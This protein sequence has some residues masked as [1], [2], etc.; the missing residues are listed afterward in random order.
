MNVARLAADIVRN[1]SGGVPRPRWCTYLVCFHCNARCGMCDSWK[2]KRGAEMTPAE[3]RTVFDKIGALDVVRLSGGEPFLRP[4]FAAVADAVWQASKPGVVH[5]TTNGSF[6][7]RVA[8]FV[9]HFA[10]PKRLRFM[11]SFDGL[12]QEHDDN[13]GANVTF[14]T[15][16]ET[17][18]LLAG[19]ADRGVKVSVNHTVISQRSLQDHDELK[20][21]FAPLGVDVQAVLAYED[22]AMYGRKRQGKR[23]DDLIPIQGYPLHPKLQGADA[24]GFVQRQLDELPAM[25][26]PLLRIG[27]RYYLRG[28]LQRLQSVDEPSPKPP[29]VALRSHIRVLPDGGVPVCQFNTERVGSLLTQSFDEVWHAPQAVAQRAWVD[30]CTGCWAECEVVPNALYSGDM[31]KEVL[32]GR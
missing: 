6:P 11:V 1:R 18:R 25:R 7:D 22:S 28:L 12:A 3:V 8:E 31:A 20:R 23:A 14:A 4:D 13:R 32:L 19:M 30:A 17:V 5:I 24:A 29:C 9:Q 21:V 15:A 27:K 2:M 16:L 26:D 10:A